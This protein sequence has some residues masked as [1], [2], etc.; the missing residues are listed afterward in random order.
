MFKSIRARMTGAFSLA[1]AVL[2]LFA[3]AALISYGRYSAEHNASETLSATVR[4]INLE[5]T[6]GESHGD[7]STLMDE[8]R[9]ELMT[10]NIVLVVMDKNGRIIMSSQQNVPSWPEFDSNKWRVAM[11]E[12]G[13]NR[14][15]AGMPWEKTG[16][17]LQYQS[18]MLLFL[19][20]LVTFAAALGAWIL[21]GRTLSPISSLSQEANTA[22]VEKLKVCLNAPSQDAEIV[23]LVATLNGLL[24]RLSI[25]AASKGRFYSAASHELRTPLQ[26]LSGHLELA[27]TRDRTIEEYRV[28]VAEAYTQTR[29]LISLAQDLLML[30]QLNSSAAMAPGEPVD[31][32]EICR[33]MLSSLKPQIEKRKLKM[34]LEIP[35]LAEISAPPNHIGIMIR[36]LLEN[37][38]RYADEDGHINLDIHIL[39]GTIRM[40]L[41]ND[42][43]KAPDFGSEDP[44]EPFSRPDFSR[45]SRLGGTGLGLAICKAIADANAW[46]LNLNFGQKCVTAVLE[47]PVHYGNKSG[48][49]EKD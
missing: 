5:I 45:N 27:L 17:A 43:R 48:V 37:A 28:V 1:I 21:V 14:I 35:D 36:N 40:D 41:S 20:L 15:I 49:D 18:T 12:A 11:T 7:L 3:S 2:M 24:S 38:V 19:S 33:S 47:I 26:A 22:S 42:Y 46:T 25:A 30:Y 31:L 13:E 4:K 8:L 9:E 6:N 29:R 23:G 44:F 10:D 34:R 39:S 32:S 16:K